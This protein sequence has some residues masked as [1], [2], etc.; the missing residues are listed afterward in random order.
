MSKSKRVEGNRW[1]GTLNNYISK[2]QPRIWFANA[3]GEIAGL[4]CGKEVGDSGTPH[5]QLYVEL[6][7]NPRNKNGRSLKWMKDHTDPK[8]HWEVAR[9]SLEHNLNYCKKEND[10]YE[11]GV[12]E[13]DK[14]SDNEGDGGVAARKTK[15]NKIEEVH[16]LIDEGWSD[17]DIARE[18]FGI[19]MHNHRALKEYRLMTQKTQ[20]TRQTKLLILTG[21]PGTGKSTRARR[22]AEAQCGP[23]GGYYFGAPE[24]GKTWLDGYIPGSKKHRVGVIEEM[25]GA[26]CMPS[27]LFR[28]C[29]GNPLRMETKG[30]SVEVC[31][32]MIIIT[33]NLLP[34]DWWSEEALPKDR[35][36]A[37]MRRCSGENG[38]I[39]HMIE[40]Y[41]PPEKT[42]EFADILSNLENGVV[43]AY[44]M[45]L[46]AI[47]EEVPEIGS[48]EDEAE[49]A[50][51]RNNNNYE[52]FGQTS[53]D[54]L[55]AVQDF[56]DDEA[57][58]DDEFDDVEEVDDDDLDGVTDSIQYEEERY[59]RPTQP[60]GTSGYKLLSG[61]VIDLDSVDDVEPPK[62]KKLKRTDENTFGVE[63]VIDKRWGKQPVQGKIRLPKRVLADADDD[64]DDK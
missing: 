38:T 31:F 14:R 44:N 1:C 12:L 23:G 50:F 30:G 58:E 2:D 39:V 51:R 11:L 40:K 16:R 64:F 60:V 8:V 15:S 62:S 46:E 33:S 5:L 27:T 25:T 3:E 18:Y 36:D 10:W 35:Y 59:M 55:P 42:F 28:L 21:P 32:D 34:R 7:R 54:D 37:L 63:K 29:D 13:G 52:D 20:R 45:P 19:W 9:G 47:K 57:E 26:T 6:K 61:G 43:D 41:V 24:N 53:E 4:I 49:A 48:D 56:I 22:I 17:L